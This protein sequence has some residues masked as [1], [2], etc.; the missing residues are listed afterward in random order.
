MPW[1]NCE[2]V[3]VCARPLYQGT[4]IQ[5]VWPYHT[6]SA[7]PLP[8]PV[9]FIYTC[10]SSHKLTHGNTQTHT[11][12]QPADANTTTH[13]NT[14]THSFTLLTHTHTHSHSHSHSHTHRHTHTFFPSITHPKTVQCITL[15]P[16][17]NW[18]SLAL[19]GPDDKYYIYIYICII[20]I[21]LHMWHDVTIASH[22]V[23]KHSE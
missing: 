17:L 8:Y 9:E 3:C 15:S 4:E 7:C 11:H 6:F 14:K 1:N 22:K 10:T 12:T 5:E 13:T 18:R 23:L 16:S 2:C 21:Y 20:Y 19:C